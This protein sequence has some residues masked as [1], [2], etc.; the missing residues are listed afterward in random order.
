MWRCR[1][2]VRIEDDRPLR[3]YAVDFPGAGGRAVLDDAPARRPRVSA[4][5]GSGFRSAARRGPRRSRDPF[6][7]SPADDVAGSWTARTAAASAAVRDNRMRIA[8]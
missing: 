8:R 2:G 5:T 4:P 6:F 1:K 7:L 3:S